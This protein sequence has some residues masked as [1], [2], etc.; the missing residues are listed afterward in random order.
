MLPQHLICIAIVLLF[1]IGIRFIRKELSKA[2]QAYAQA[3]EQHKA[4]EV[5]FTKE[6]VEAIDEQV[7]LS[8]EW[9]EMPHYIAN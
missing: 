9:S 7:D 8:W 3:Q 1:T 5:V 2:D 6:E 4:Q